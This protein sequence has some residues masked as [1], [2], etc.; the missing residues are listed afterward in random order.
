MKTVYLSLDNGESVEK[1]KDALVALFTGGT[2]NLILDPIGPVNVEKI[3]VHEHGGPIG[4]KTSRK[5]WW[6]R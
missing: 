2:G 1:I 4:R 3:T 6:K 5:A